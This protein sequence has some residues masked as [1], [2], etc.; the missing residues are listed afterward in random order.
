MSVGNILAKT[1]GVIGLGLIGYDSHVAGTIRSRSFEKEHKAAS[2]EHHLMSDQKQESA[3]TIRGHLKKGLFRYQMDEEFSG[4]FTGIVGYFKG[5]N[6]M[7]IR[8]VIPLVLAAGTFAGK[9]GIRGGI[10]KCSAVG[11][12]AYGLVTL[13]QEIFGIGKSE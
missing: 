11:L 5:V 9:N 10:S 2:L 7:L 3:S 6:S 4:F 8:N 1:A 13:A 12:A